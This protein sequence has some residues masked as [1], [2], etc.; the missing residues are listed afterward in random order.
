MFSY[1]SLASITTLLIYVI[2]ARYLSQDILGV[3]I[4]Q[5]GLVELLNVI[6]N[7][8]SWQT[9]LRFNKDGQEGLLN[10]SFIADVLSSIIV[11][12]V[13]IVLLYFNVIDLSIYSNEVLAFA[14]FCCILFFRFADILIG[15]T[16]E[17]DDFDTIGK[18][19][20]LVGIVRLAFLFPLLSHYQDVSYLLYSFAIYYLLDVTIKIIVL[21]KRFL[22][23]IR[24][25]DLRRFSLKS[26]YFIFLIKQNIDVSIRSVSRYL[27]IVVI[28]YIGSS[29][30]TANF[31]IAKE[32]SILA[33]KL[34]DPFYSI[35]YPRMMKMDIISGFTFL[36][37][38]TL[39]GI[40]FSVISFAVLYV[41]GEAIISLM[42]GSGF[43][44][45][46]LFLRIYFIGIFCMISGISLAPFMYAFGKVNSIIFI[47]LFS[48]ISFIIMIYLSWIFD[49][50]YLIVCAFPVYY[51]SWTMASYYYSAYLK[52]K[53]EEDMFC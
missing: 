42:Y 40:L 34:S 46:S 17:I 51:I 22:F 36:R 52:K 21:R 3:F 18:Y 50:Y 11:L 49:N 35:I 41:F 5:I 27:D 8:Q 33:T 2:S 15:V 45:S 29:V 6:F 16:R 10:I 24:L 38:S 47:Q 7:F 30:I 28:Y 19:L 9:Y 31:K 32:I 48:T 26:E 14:A 39:L 13:G 4:Y 23:R 43:E 44:Y 37:R 1:N 12:L 20:L 25:D 53:Y